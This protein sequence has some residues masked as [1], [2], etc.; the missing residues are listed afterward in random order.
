MKKLLIIVAT[1]ALGIYDNARAD[2]T[3]PPLTIGAALAEADTNNPDVLAARQAV[4]I[5]VARL[6]Q[7]VPSALRAQAEDAMSPDVP[8]GLGELE[9]HS[10]GVVQQFDPPGVLAAARQSA[11]AAVDGARASFAVER[12]DI[13]QRVIVAFYAL[14]G[15]TALVGVNAENVQV[16][17]EFVNSA[18]K[19]VRAGAAGNFEVLRATNELRRAQSDFMR[20]QTDEQ[21]ARIEINTLLDRSPDAQTIVAAGP[22]DLTVRSMDELVAQ[23]LAS[24]PQSA[25]IRAQLAQAVAEQRASQLR[26][27]PAVSIGVGTQTTTA[28][29]FPSL[30][31]GPVISASL[32]FPL[33]DFGT[34]RGATHEAQAASAVAAL[35]LRGRDRWVH[36]QVVQAVAAL[37]AARAQLEF[38]RDSQ[39]HAEEALRVAEYGYRQGALGTLDVLAARNAAI[40]ARGQVERSAAD[41]ASAIAR[42][43]L[44]EGTTPSP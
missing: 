4:E 24:D 32:S 34:I 8:G 43:Q 29:T 16:T 30:S 33:F 18:R 17:G 37:R 36:A 15:A 19:R 40:G 2:T 22:T 10:I 14:V 39:M 23:A 6:E 11:R 3:F 31:K 28:A 26:R 21:S 9:I 27:L 25:V 20:S 1:L 7:T 12:R 35:Q 44:I 13:E 42:L 5:Q 41:A 38:A